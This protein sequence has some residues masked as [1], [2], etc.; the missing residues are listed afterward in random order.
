M[1]RTTTLLDRLNVPF[2]MP[3]VPHATDWLALP[4]E[5]P[6]TITERTPM[7]LLPAVALSTLRYYAPAVECIHATSRFADRRSSLR[8]KAGASSHQSRRSPY[9]T[10]HCRPASWWRSGPTCSAELRQACNGGAGVPAAG[11][12]CVP[13][14]LR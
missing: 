10:C 2:V 14:L 3:W 9:G 12:V 1:P 5:A 13:A 6:V 11:L 4:Q 7:L 8:A